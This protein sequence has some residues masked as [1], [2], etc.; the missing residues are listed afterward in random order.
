MKH[1]KIQKKALS[2]FLIMIILIS[3]L[4]LNTAAAGTFL[5]NAD[6]TIS[7]PIA[8]ERPSYSATINSDKFEVIDEEYGYIYHGVTWYDWTLDSNIDYDDEFVEGHVYSVTVLIR[9]TAGNNIGLLN[10]TV[11]GN[12]AELSET[13]DENDNPYYLVQYCFGEK[14]VIS[15]ETADITI[16]EPVAGEL[17]SYEATIGNECFE[18]IDEEFGYVYHGVTWYD[19]TLDSNIDYDDEFVEGHVYSVTILVKK[20]EGCELEL[21]YATVNG[22]SAEISET[23][24]DYDNPYYLVQYYFGEKPTNIDE[25]ADITITEPV[26]GELPSY[27]ATIG[28]ECFEVIY[29]EYGYVYQG[30]TWYDWTLDSN[31]DKNDVFVE[32][33][34]YSVT[35]LVKKAEG[36]ELDLL[37][38][39][40]NGNSAELSETTDDYGNPYYLVQYCFGEKPTNIDETVDITITEPIAGQRPSYEATIG[41]ECFE[42]VDEEY[43]YV[44]QGVTWYDW[45]LDSNIDKNDVFVEGHIYSVTVLVKKAAGVELDLLYATVN[46]NKAEVEETDDYYFVSYQF[47]IETDAQI[48]TSV[49]IFHI[50]EP[51]TG[52]GFDYTATLSGSGY[53]T[54]NI[55]NSTTINGISWF[56][57]TDEKYVETT[58]VCVEGH[59]YSAIIQLEAEDGYI[60][61][62]EIVKINGEE[63]GFSY[64]GTDVVTEAYFEYV[65]PYIRNIELTD[66]NFPVQFDAPDYSITTDSDKYTFADKNDAY[67]SEGVA[68]FDVSEGRYL[69]IGTDTFVGAHIYMIEIYLVPEE[70][71]SFDLTSVTLNGEIV[72][73][74]WGTG[75]RV[76]LYYQFEPCE[77]RTDISILVTAIGGDEYSSPRVE[78]IDPKSDEIL[79]DTQGQSDPSY[80]GYLC[81]LEFVY[82]TSYIMRVTR[83]GCTPRYYNISVSSYSYAFTADIFG[84]GDVNMDGVVD[85]NDY[86]ACVNLALEDSEVPEDT[87]KDTDYRKALADVCNDGV[88]DV[89]DC[90]YAEKKRVI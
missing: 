54:K 9:N 25:T 8:G 53:K 21:L 58:D 20:A 6:I 64:E 35:V 31:I 19:W 13:T 52:Y 63:V 80:Q 48:I 55:N 24:D 75:S 2:I 45:T 76:I 56:D 38:A 69:E 89:L 36:V 47:Y 50:S 17:P 61:L 71:F 67:F 42:V 7:A 66:V 87:T 28:N 37:Y 59:S 5:K 73:D 49:N 90:F 3:T 44:Y 86:Q 1:L 78:L 85:V 43:G 57:C 83:E 16:T 11:N 10:A 33:H 77:T 65:D 51:T 81:K 22:N 14:P 40:V 23:T 4:S 62:P 79:Y 72:T 26:A 41:N 30:V 74:I 18:V 12:E 29:E 39:T 68:W 88:I 15:D 34:I 82:P 70:G 60:L 46:G 32:G 84:E 27:D